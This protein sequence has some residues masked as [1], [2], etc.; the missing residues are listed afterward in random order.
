MP[1]TGPDDSQALFSPC[2]QF[3]ST[4][5]RSQDGSSPVPVPTVEAVE[6]AQTLASHNSHVYMPTEPTVA[7][8]SPV[9]AAVALVV[10][11]DV[12]HV[13]SLRSH[14]WRCPSMFCAAMRRDSYSSSLV[15]W[16]LG[17]SYFFFFF[18]FDPTLYMAIHWHLLP[19]LLEHTSMSGRRR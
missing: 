15:T 1:E 3:R 14:Q 13:L 6:A 5:I 19:R 18:F 16:P 7:K 12:R 17:L 8:T 9:S 11:S 10:H 2:H 4:E